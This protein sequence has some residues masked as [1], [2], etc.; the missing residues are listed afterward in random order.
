[1]QHVVFKSS[2]ASSN[3]GTTC[4]YVHRDRYIYT[5]RIISRIKIVRR[6]RISPRNVALHEID[7]FPRDPPRQSCYTCSFP[8]QK[9][10]MVVLRRIGHSRIIRPIK[11]NS[12]LELFKPN[13][14]PFFHVFIHPQLAFIPYSRSRSP[15]PIPES[16]SFNH[17]L[18][19]IHFFYIHY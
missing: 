4:T 8:H 7:P 18:I 10:S 19:L 5:R 1:M 17:N 9:I 15:K 6:C 11:S 16:Q 2:C 3:H 13:L 12:I 14:A